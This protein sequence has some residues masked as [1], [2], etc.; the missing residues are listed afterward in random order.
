MMTKVILLV[1]VIAAAVWYFDFSRRM[2]D[3][4]IRASYQAQ[5]DALGQFD[6]EPICTAMDDSYTASV[7]VR[8]SDS[9]PQKT[10]G[11]AA[12]CATWTKA[13]HR[14]KLLSERTGGMLEP[15]FDFE[16]KSITLTPNHKSATV[17]ISSAMRLGNMTL[18][19]SQSIE[20]LIRRNGRILST[21][22]EDTVWVYQGE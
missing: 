9:T 8:G 10:H 2:T 14:L 20:H 18:S 21:G 1:L 12:A 22:S 16:I 6:A 5:I 19:R 13:M 17:E 3:A 7:T 15:D 4:S 11:K